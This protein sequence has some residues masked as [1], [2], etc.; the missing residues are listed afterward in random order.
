LR[1]VKNKKNQEKE[2]LGGLLTKWTRNWWKSVPLLIRWDMIELHTDRGPYLDFNTG[3]R[4][5]INLCTVHI[6][7]LWRVTPVLRSYCVW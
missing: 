4:E 7:C 1:L 3:Q 6:N 2:K 5:S